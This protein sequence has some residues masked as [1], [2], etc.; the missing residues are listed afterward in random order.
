MTLLKA[1]GRGE[2]EG[3]GQDSCFSFGKS[4]LPKGFVSH[5]TEFLAVFHSQCLSAGIRLEAEWRNRV[6][7]LVLLQGAGRCCIPERAGAE[8]LRTLLFIERKKHKHRRQDSELSDIER[9]LAHPSI[10][11]TKKPL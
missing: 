11:I 9:P 7:L 8:P 10:S 3:E 6:Q 5:C 4:K 1:Q 2:G